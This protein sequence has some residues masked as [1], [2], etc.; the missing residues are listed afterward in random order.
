M[1]KGFTTMRSLVP[2][3]RHLFLVLL[4]IF[5]LTGAQCAPD[6]KYTA[7]PSSQVKVVPNSGTNWSYG[8]FT[9]DVVAHVPESHLFEQVN[10]YRQGLH[11]HPLRWHDGMCLV[12]DI[13]AQDMM[14][15]NYLGLVSP[16]G[17]DMFERMVSSNPRIDFDQAYA[18][19]AYTDSASNVFQ[20][21]IEVPDSRMVIEDPNM[22]HFGSRFR[23][24]A[25]GPTHSAILFARN[26]RP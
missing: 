22:T 14:N 19:V 1:R 9:Y 11:L 17:I 26:A 18:F 24:P 8:N 13:H 15:Q 23:G 20:Q 10:A 6:K 5:P 12:A 16:Q 2:F 3:R 25:S 7:G 4:A 21:L